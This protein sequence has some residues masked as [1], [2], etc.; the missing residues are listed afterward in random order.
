MVYAIA[1]KLIL[2]PEFYWYHIGDNSNRKTISNGEIATVMQILNDLVTKMPNKKIVAWCGRIQNARQWI[3]IFNEE[4]KKRTNLTNFKFYLDTSQD[5]NSD[6][7][8]FKKQDSECILFCAN[9]HREGS[10]IRHLDGCIFIDKVKNRGSIPFI[11]SIGRVLSC[12]LYT[13][14][15]ADES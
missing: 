14:D 13:S 3:K 11:Q 6:Y 10:D 8:K 9:K 2:P 5:T 15:A 1:N 12:L 7:K 4:H